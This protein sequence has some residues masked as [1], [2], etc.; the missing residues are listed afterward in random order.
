MRKF[1]KSLKV[2]Y[3]QYGDKHKKNEPKLEP[4]YEVKVSCE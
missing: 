2:I 1:N 3:S 4:Y